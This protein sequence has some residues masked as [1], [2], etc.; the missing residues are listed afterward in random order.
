MSRPGRWVQVEG[1]VHGAVWRMLTCELAGCGCEA[2]VE[3]MALA[4]SSL[5]PMWR[6]WPSPP[7]SLLTIQPGSWTLVWLQPGRV[8]GGPRT[9]RC[10]GSQRSHL[11]HLSTLILSQS[12]LYAP[13]QSCTLLCTRSKLICA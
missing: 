4:Q 3:A 5:S 12:Y 11:A 8:L 6:S 7:S 13:C 10:C 9:V 1:E 2:Y